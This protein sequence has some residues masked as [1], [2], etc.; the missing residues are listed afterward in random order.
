MCESRHQLIHMPYNS[1]YL[2]DRNIRPTNTTLSAH[3][4]NRLDHGLDFSN[5]QRH[6][7]HMVSTCRDLRFATNHQTA[8][9]ENCITTDKHYSAIAQANTSQHQLQRTL[10]G[11]TASTASSTTLLT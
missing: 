1:D 10:N 8:P 2:F 6:H 9:A 11:I 5:Q 3:I 7:H 4:A